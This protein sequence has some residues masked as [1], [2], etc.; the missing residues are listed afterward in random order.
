MLMQ[1]SHSSFPTLIAPFAFAIAVC[2]L[3]VWL[4][5]I[6]LNDRLFSPKLKYTRCQR[7]AAFM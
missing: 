3:C 4:V 6:R 1:R 7:P 5:Y 2:S